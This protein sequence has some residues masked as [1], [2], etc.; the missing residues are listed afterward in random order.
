MAYYELYLHKMIPPFRIQG[1]FVNVLI[2]MTRVVGG[3]FLSFVYGAEVF[4]MPW[5][6]KKYDLAFFEVADWFV[7]EVSQFGPPFEYMPRLFAWSAGFTMAIGGILWVLGLN[8][9]ATAFFVAITMF[10]T[11]MLRSWNDTWHI[12]PTF[13]LFCLGLVFLLLGSGRFG[14]DAMITKRYL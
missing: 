8:T 12:L 11:I 10:I 9:R 3:F 13:L 2:M 1:I 4:G 5:T 6:S 14:M 7:V